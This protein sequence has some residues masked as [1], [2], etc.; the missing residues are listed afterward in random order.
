MTTANEQE[1][2]VGVDGSA[3]SAAAVRWALTEAKASGRTVVALRAWT[4]DPLADIESAVS[5]TPSEIA[6]RY[7]HE[8]DHVLD[9]ARGDFEGVRVRSGTIDGAPGPALVR[10]S[11][12]AAMLVL[13]SHGHSRVLRLLVGSV[14]EYCLRQSRCPV[15]IVPARSA[16]E[17]EPL[18]DKETAGSYYPGPL[19]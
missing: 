11:A 2:V 19:L 10:A 7:Q 8:L 9:E 17:R 14:S 16:E 12:D 4:F 13:G 15:V 1:I 6:S 18:P 5:R 3:G